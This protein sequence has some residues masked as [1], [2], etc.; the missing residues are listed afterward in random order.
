MVYG[1]KISLTTGEAYGA[2]RPGVQ[3][4]NLLKVESWKLVRMEHPIRRG[5]GLVNLI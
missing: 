4:V 2:L 5:H 3:Y 1:W